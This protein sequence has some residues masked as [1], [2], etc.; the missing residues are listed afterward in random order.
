[1]EIYNTRA[2]YG[3]R[4]AATPTSTAVSND[5]NIGLPS[6]SLTL[7][8]ADTIWAAQA[9]LVGSTTDLVLTLAAS[10][11]TGTT[12]WTAGTAQ[13]ETNT[14]VAAG[15]ATSTGT[16]TLVVTAA[17]LTGSPLNVP[18]SLDSAV[19]TTAAL[20][21]AAGR[22]A[23]AANS[24][25]AAMFTVGGSSAAISL[26]R[27]PLATYKVGANSVPTYPANDA[28]LNLAIPSGLGITASATSTNTTAGVISAGCYLADGDG[29]DFE[30]V[31]LTP[32]AAANLGSFILLNHAE[33]SG[34]VTVS[35]VATLADFPVPADGILQ[36]AAK[37]CNG[38]L[39]TLTIE[40][41]S[42]ALVTLV[43]TGSTV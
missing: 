9:L 19:H 15:G 31:T 28:T 12:A 38:T 6:T 16:M 24:A 2:F 32:I 27:K 41:L 26:T 30:G 5:N 13:V 39:E 43:V 8:D 14:V 1:M 17:G 11:S 18:V 34:G 36:F 35:T 33:S 7:A 29:K 20:I 22:A 40:P 3:L 37:N 4:S 21:A 42:T 10:D 25:V 23:L